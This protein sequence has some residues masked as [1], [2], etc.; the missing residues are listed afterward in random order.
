MAKTKVKIE[1]TEPEVVVNN[2]EP[3][4]ETNETQSIA[5]PSGFSLEK[6]KAEARAYNRW[7]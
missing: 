7:R 3:K 5:K 6:F 2:T 1:S 4:V